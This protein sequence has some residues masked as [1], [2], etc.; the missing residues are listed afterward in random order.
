MFS[1]G[2]ACKHFSARQPEKNSPVGTHAMKEQT[3]NILLSRERNVARLTLNRPDVIN[4]FN[5]KMRADFSRMIRKVQAD[6]HVRVIVIDGAGTRGFCA[7]ADVN[8]EREIGSPIRERERLTPSSWI[9]ALDEVTKPVIAVLHGF[10][11]GGG[12]E[13]ALACDIRMASSDLQLGLTETRLGLIPGGGGTQRLPRLIGL[14][15]ALDLLISADR[16]DADRAYQMGIVTRLSADKDTVLAD[17]MKLASKIAE[18]PPAAI[19][20]AKEAAIEGLSSNLRGGLRL[21][22]ALFALLMGTE[23]RKEAAAAFAEKRDPSF[24]GY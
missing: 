12:L 10:C 14:G 23:D 6:E 13:I 20:F 7:G 4:A 5:N 11:F 15:P 1:G 8:E 9:E 18:R 24:K 16:I 2:G 22:K 21:E 17:A 19:A 3:E